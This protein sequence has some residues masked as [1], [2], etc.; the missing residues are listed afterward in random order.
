MRTAGSRYFV[1]A[2]LAGFGLLAMETAL[3]GIDQLTAVRFAP[4]AG[5]VIVAGLSTFVSPP[6]RAWL[7][8]AAFILTLMM[9]ILLLFAWFYPLH[10]IPATLMAVAFA[11]AIQEN[12]RLA[13]PSM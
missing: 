12:E 13:S 8:L 2:L 11:L 1:A 7:Y 9:A 3:D 10:L 6:V 4:Y 5:G